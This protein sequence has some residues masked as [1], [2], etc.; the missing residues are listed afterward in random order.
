MEYP[1]V[2]QE[3]DNQYENCDEAILAIQQAYDAINEAQARLNTYEHDGYT[4]V[5]NVQKANKIQVAILEYYRSIL[6][7]ISHIRHEGRW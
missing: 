4:P 3:T 6:E 7:E 5:H 1:K 2:T